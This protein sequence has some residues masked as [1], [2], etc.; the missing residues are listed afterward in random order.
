MSLT[1]TEP[2]FNSQINEQDTRE[3]ENE[4]VNESTAE[5]KD[6][7]ETRKR[8]L[9]IQGNEHEVV[10]DMG[11][12]N[13]PLQLFASETLHY[14]LEDES[15]DVTQV[16]AAEEAGIETMILSDIFVQNEDLVDL[17]NLSIFAKESKNTHI[18]I[19]PNPQDTQSICTIQDE[20]NNY[21]QKN[22]S[23]FKDDEAF[24]IFM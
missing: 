5:F 20:S 17:E 23:V 8:E 6:D 13:V 14:D 21:T 2:Q 12:G 16:A 4:Q 15:I 1:K 9:D 3:S 18:E 7:K 24:T 19:I 10:L 22:N 11:Q